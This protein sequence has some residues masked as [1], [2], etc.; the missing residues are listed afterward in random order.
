[1]K[2][3][4]SLVA[5]ALL[6][7]WSATACG[8]SSQAQTS[9]PT[10]SSQA[11]SSSAPPPASAKLVVVKAGV[12]T[13]SMG[14]ADYGIV[15]QNPTGS[16]ALDVQLQVNLDRGGSIL[17]TDTQ[18]ISLVPA[19][20]TYYVG[21]GTNLSSPTPA[22]AKVAVSSSIGQSVTAKYPNIKVTQL[23]IGNDG[24]GNL[25]AHGVVTN[26]TTGPLASYAEIGIVYFNR[27][28][29]VVGGSDTFP[30]ATLAP[31]GQAAFNDPILVAS[32]VHVT[33]IEASCENR[34]A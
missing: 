21:G 8:M 11:G 17:A 28:G 22:P 24:Y 1:M 19:H 15:L 12:S 13:D 2:R 16:D 31:G 18:T 4:L 7:T 10:V 5:V 6:L 20:T 26:N 34:S 25:T 27:A 29:N 23:K 30:E 9:T 3:P 33:R 14:T 32:G